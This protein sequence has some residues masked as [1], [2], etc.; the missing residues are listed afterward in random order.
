MISRQR[1][2]IHSADSVLLATLFG[3]VIFGLIAL[4][5]ASTVAGYENFRDS[6]YY[7][8][9]QILYGVLIGSAGF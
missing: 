1:G 8:W 7:V 5:S 3:L 4:S 6:N 9:H 2:N